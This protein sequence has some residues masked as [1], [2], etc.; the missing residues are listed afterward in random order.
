MDQKKKTFTA[1]TQ[2]ALLLS[3][4]ACGVVFAIGIVSWLLY[5]YSPTGEYKAGNLILEPSVLGS[6][7]HTDFSKDKKRTLVKDLI[8]FQNLEGEKI[9]V[10]TDQYA[11][12][13]AL[14]NNDISTDLNE[15]NENRQA[16]LEIYFRED[17]DRVPKVF[18][19]IVFFPYS[20]HYKIKVFSDNQENAYFYH[21]DIYTKILEIL[22]K[23][24]R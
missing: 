9:Q 7:S 18:Q 13:Y 24:E 20:H 11:E 12:I 21:P 10:T 23:H 1:K 16:S 14:L 15:V 6:L 19:T 17:F 3:T 2:I 5:S 22:K 4:L 8:L